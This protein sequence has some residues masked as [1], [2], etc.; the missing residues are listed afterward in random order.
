[1]EKG[2]GVRV[3]SVAALFKERLMAIEAKYQKH[4]VDLPVIHNNAFT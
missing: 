2:G 4:A 3:S 1:M